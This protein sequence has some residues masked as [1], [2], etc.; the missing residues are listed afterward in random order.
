MKRWPYRQISIRTVIQIELN[1]YLAVREM[2]GV[3]GGVGSLLS[4]FLHVDKLQECLFETPDSERDTV[5]NFILCLVSGILLIFY[6]IFQKLI[7]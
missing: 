3:G 7:S 1:V 6:F 5:L 2:G 4:G